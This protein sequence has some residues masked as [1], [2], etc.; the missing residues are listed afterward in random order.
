MPARLDE[1][2][3]LG[4]VG[5]ELASSVLAVLRDAVGRADAL[6]VVLHD[7]QI[8]NATDGLL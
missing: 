2:G 6:S 3:H 7:D 1:S 4:R 5:P 8:V